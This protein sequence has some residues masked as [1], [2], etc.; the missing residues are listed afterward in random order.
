LT[1]WTED[2]YSGS[3]TIWANIYKAHPPHEFMKECLAQFDSKMR[4]DWA[5]LMLIGELWQ[6]DPLCKNLKPGGE[7]GSFP[8]CNKGKKHSAESRANMS[9]AHA[10]KPSPNKGKKIGPQSDEHRANLSEANKG[11][12]K[13]EE[14]KAKLRASRLA[15]IAK[16]KGV[17]KWPR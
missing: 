13:S 6:C 10:G 12:P 7:G 14:H 9:A 11:I 4:N 16:K 15:T 17:I 2:K 3:G 1:H 8:G 5:E